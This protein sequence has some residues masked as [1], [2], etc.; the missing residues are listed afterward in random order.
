MVLYSDCETFG[1]VVIESAASG[2]PVILSDIP[3]FHELVDESMGVFV[4]QDNSF[5]LGVQ[6]KEM[7]TKRNRFDSTTMARKM[8]ERF[9]YK[10]VGKQ[11]IDWY[12]TVMKP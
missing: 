10:S 2:V 8:E 3:V 7:I 4:P 5:A 9:G 12:E 1:C 11:F 6:M